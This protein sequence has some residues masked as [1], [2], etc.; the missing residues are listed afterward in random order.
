MQPQVDKLKHG[1]LSTETQGGQN[2]STADRILDGLGA[3][4][5]FIVIVFLMGVV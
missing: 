5:A 1:V 3:G 2:M 4:L